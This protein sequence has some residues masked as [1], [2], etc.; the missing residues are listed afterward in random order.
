MK[1]YMQP[2]RYDSYLGKQGCGLLVYEFT[3]IM[4]VLVS[5]QI[6]TAAAFFPECLKHSGK[7]KKH[8][9]KI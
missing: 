6:T 7:S 4:Y 1:S 3:S 5:W 8:S 9:G 2:Y